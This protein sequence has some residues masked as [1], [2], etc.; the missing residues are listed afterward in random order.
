M[1]SMNHKRTQDFGSGGGGK[2][3]RYSKLKIIVAKKLENSI[4]NEHIFHPDG[5]INK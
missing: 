3:Q 4:E 5:S 2:V 1:Y